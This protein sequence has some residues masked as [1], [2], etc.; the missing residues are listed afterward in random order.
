MELVDY[1][2][3]V[4]PAE[5]AMILRSVLRA[6]RSLKT[7][8]FIEGYPSNLLIEEF[9]TFYLARIAVFKHSSHVFD[10]EDNIRDLLLKSPLTSN[11]Q[12]V[13][14]FRFADSMHEPGIQPSD[15]V[16]GVLGKMHS[17]FTIRNEMRWP[18]IGR[19]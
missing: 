9:S 11:G 15:V 8:D 3:D 12:P 13:T 6:G 17:Y 5:N 14:N 2:K 7:L 19:H 4:L 10:M 1:H 16:V 18:K